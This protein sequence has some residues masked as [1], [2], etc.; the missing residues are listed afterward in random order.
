MNKQRIETYIAFIIVVLGAVFLRLI[1]HIPNV[2]PIGA[3]ALFSGIM[4]PSLGA[5]LFPFAAMFISDLFL[6]FHATLPYVYGSFA[7]IVGLG[8]VT[9]KKVNLFIVGFASITGSVLFFIITNFGVWATGRMYAKNFSGLVEAYAMGLPFFRN[10]L[11]GD[12]FFNLLFFAGYHFLL[13]ISKKIALR[14]RY[15][16]HYYL[17]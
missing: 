15:L 2:N 6:G 10:T 11:V 17:S 16:S 13:F 1:P 4:V 7:L 3:L 5:V 14:I 8:Y 12:V 9:R